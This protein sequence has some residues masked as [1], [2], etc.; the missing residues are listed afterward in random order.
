[1]RLLS[2][3]AAALVALAVGC[4]GGSPPEG[5]APAETQ[6]VVDTPPT[7]PTPTT[8]ASPATPTEPKPLSGLPAFTAG[9]EE[10]TKLNRK[11]IPP[12]ESGDAHL[13]RKNIFASKKRRASGSFPNGT[14]LVKEAVRPGKDFIGLI[15]IMR[16]ERGLDR[17]HND[18][19]FVEYTRD[20][21]AARFAV[22]ASDSVCWSCHIDAQQT[23][24]VWIYT[25]GLAR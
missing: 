7:N 14:I 11:P 9:Y 19:R 15:A 4:G 1:M 17:D 3:L 18:W 24:Y 12:R 22:T 10:W 20:S 23:D 5:A 2:A 21:A 25:L 8:T 13:G 6:T 16:K